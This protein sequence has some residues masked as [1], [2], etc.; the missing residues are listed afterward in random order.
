MTAHIECALIGRWRIIEADLW[1]RAFLDLM[2]PAQIRF[3][4]NG[5]GEFSFGCVNGN[6]DCEYSARTIFFTWQGN[7][8]MDEASGDG[9]A[10]LG[11]DG[12]IELEI[13]FHHGDEAVLKATRW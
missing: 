4:D 9:S 7:D 10:E 13:R 3:Q 1:D 2:Q 11:D 5:H 12:A 8:E 6:L